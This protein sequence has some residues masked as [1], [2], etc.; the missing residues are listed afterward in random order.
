MHRKRAK[1]KPL[2]DRKFLEK[3]SVRLAED[4]ERLRESEVPLAVRAGAAASWDSFVS[5]MLPMG[6]A[7]VI[8]STSLSFTFVASA[9]SG[10]MQAFYFYSGIL[11]VMFV[12][13]AVWLISAGRR[14]RSHVAVRE[15]T[16]LRVQHRLDLGMLD[17]SRRRHVRKRREQEDPFPFPPHA[18]KQKRLFRRGA[19]R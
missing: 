13:M 17:S 19:G 16:S 3:V 15:I 5:L 1:P 9:N 7:V 10:L 2:A 12:S 14:Q 18:K 6:V 8:A 11:A 4:G